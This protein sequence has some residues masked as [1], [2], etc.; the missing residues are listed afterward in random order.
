MED[1]E[2]KTEE[3]FGDFRFSKISFGSL[4]YII[5]I[6]LELIV[7]I[8]L[9]LEYYDTLVNCPRIRGQKEK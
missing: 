3:I 4:I 6:C 5:T 7:F 9:C 8:E 1:T 2:T